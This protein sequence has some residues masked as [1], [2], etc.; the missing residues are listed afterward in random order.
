MHFLHDF[1]ICPPLLQNIFFMAHF[2]PL[3]GFFVLLPYLFSSFWSPFHS[4][5]YCTCIFASSSWQFILFTFM[6][7]TSFPFFNFYAASCFRP[8]VIHHCSSTTSC[9]FSFACC[10]FCGHNHAFLSSVNFDIML[11]NVNTYFIPFFSCNVLKIL[12]QNSME[13]K[14]FR[15]DELSTQN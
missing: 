9:A 10:I 3:T 2:L 13:Q 1:H 8:S 12:N 7:F 11:L 4:S 15:C 5:S 6:F 14:H